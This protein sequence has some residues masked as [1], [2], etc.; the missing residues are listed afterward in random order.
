MDKVYRKMI[1]R[2]VMYL[3]L[4]SSLMITMFVCCNNEGR[5]A[6]TEINR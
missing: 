4:I 5:K 1:I 3:V 6:K 2:W